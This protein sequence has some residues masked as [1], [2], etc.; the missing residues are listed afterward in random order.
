MKE[1]DI[2]RKIIKTLE[3]AGAYVVKVVSAT[4]SG[5]PDILACYKGTFIGIEVKTP[6]TSTNVSKLQAYNLDKIR[7]CGGLAI[8]AWDVSHVEVLIERIDNVRGS[9]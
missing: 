3:S 9:N 4:K 5:V 6:K 7:D 1:Q 2:Q 8:V